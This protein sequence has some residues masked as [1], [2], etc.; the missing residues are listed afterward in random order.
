[1]KLEFI[2]TDG[3]TGDKLTF[4]E[5]SIADGEY[6]RRI[7]RHITGGPGGIGGVTGLA[8]PTGLVGLSPVNG[9]LTTAMRSDGAP[10][11]SQAI[12][13]TW[14]NDHIWSTDKKNLYRDANTFVSSK[15][16]GY[17]DFDASTGF[18]FNTGKLGIGV[19]PTYQL[20]VLNNQ[21]LATIVR[22]KNT[23]NTNNT[24]GTAQ[25]RAETYDGNTILLGVCP[26]SFVTT[27]YRD[28]G[29]LFSYSNSGLIIEEQGNFPIDFYTNS[30]SRMRIDGIGNLGISRAPEAIDASYHTVCFGICDSLMSK[31]A[32]TEELFLLSNCYYDG[33]W[34]N[35]LDRCVH[36]YVMYNGTHYWKSDASPGAAGTAFTP[37]VRM[38][39]DIS[40]NLGI[41]ITPWASWHTGYN[42]L[43]IGALSSLIGAVDDASFSTY[44]SCNLQ[45]QAGG[46]YTTS[47]HSGRGSL[48]MVADGEF[49]FYNTVAQTAGTATRIDTLKIDASANLLLKNAGVGTNG[50]GVLC[51][52]NNTAP[53]A[54]VDNC[55]QIYSVDVDND[56]TPAASLGIFTE[57]PVENAVLDCV[58]SIKIKHNGVTVNLMIGE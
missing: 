39:L 49:T 2:E 22:V 9:I 7:G 27:M 3:K 18:R 20:D 45:L 54:H 35:V 44:L 36:Q 50:I 46:W 42:I 25:Y 10:A 58:G 32:A 16:S 19:S 37:T 12:A 8:N 33:S 14:T 43:Q 48:L 13:P 24:D 34:R 4:G 11:L 30:T 31:R 17:L 28:K 57:M 26:D 5:T 53:S 6:L 21:N 47:P 15:N 55:V 1:M 23:D 38:Q 52:A 40:G 51:L 29:I 41:G 56:G